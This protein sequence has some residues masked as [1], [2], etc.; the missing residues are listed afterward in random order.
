MRY[1]ICQRYVIYHSREWEALVE[2]GWV[3]HIVIDEP[4]VDG[5]RVALMVRP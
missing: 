5:V 2:Q 4:F 1:V 3:T